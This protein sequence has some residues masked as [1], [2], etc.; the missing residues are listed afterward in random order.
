MPNTQ[1]NLKVAFA[2]E[3]Q[4]NRKYTAFA[5]KA[6][7]DGFPHVAKLF[8]AAAEATQEAVLN[9]MV[10]APA[11]TGRDGHHRPSLGDWPRANAG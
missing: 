9:A 10:A 7:K 11:T 5:Q 1:E 6:D 4:A 2:G 3:S 8:R